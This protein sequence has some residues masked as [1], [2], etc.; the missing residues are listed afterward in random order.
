MAGCLLRGIFAVTAGVAAGYGTPVAI[1]RATDKF[2]A[3]KAEETLE[4]I[5]KLK[6]SRGKER[7]RLLLK[8]RG[9]VNFDERVYEEALKRIEKSQESVT[10][11]M[12]KRI[13]KFKDNEIGEMVERVKKFIKESGIKKH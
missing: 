10:E 6:E 8:S 1:A 7:T 11:E 3:V 12:A 5:K 9:I 2:Q 4:E 13:D